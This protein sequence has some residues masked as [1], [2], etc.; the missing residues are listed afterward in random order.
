[1]CKIGLV[2]AKAGACPRESGE[3]GDLK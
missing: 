2:P 1:L 3:R